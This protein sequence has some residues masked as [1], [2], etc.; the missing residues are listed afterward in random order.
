LLRPFKG[1]RPKPIPTRWLGA[2]ETHL[3]ALEMGEL[4][5][6]FYQ[7][8]FN[9]EEVQKGLHSLKALG[10]GTVHGVYQA[11]KIRHFHKLWDQ[12]IY[13]DRAKAGAER[14]DNAPQET[15]HGA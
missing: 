2:H 1:E 6:I 4:A 15:T 9:I 13:G 7:D 12:W 11:G 14:F 3:D 8:E 10:R 5:R